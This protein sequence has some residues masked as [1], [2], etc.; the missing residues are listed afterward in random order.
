MDRYTPHA[1]LRLEIH[2][3][4][5]ELATEKAAHLKMV[6]AQSLSETEAR[7]LRV[8]LGEAVSALGEAEAA[9]AVMVE[10]AKAVAKHNDDIALNRRREALA[11]AV[12]NLPTAVQDYIEWVSLLENVADTSRR[13]L[14]LDEA[15]G[16]KGRS[17]LAHYSYGNAFKRALSELYAYEGRRKAN[18]VRKD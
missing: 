18:L 5:Q 4:R 14:K 2:S 10:A 8:Q 17:F 11:A 1:D 15:S 3:L 9:C 6:H 12:L 7:Q 13:I 16:K